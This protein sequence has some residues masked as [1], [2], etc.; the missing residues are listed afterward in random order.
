MITTKRQIRTNDDRY[1]ITD[2][3]DRMNTA[4]AAEDIRLDRSVD[5]KDGFDNRAEFADIVMPSAPVRETHEA[6]NFSSS[7]SAAERMPVIESKNA[8]EEKPL[9]TTRETINTELPP[10]PVKEQKPH[11][12]E[13]V[14][15][16][17]KTLTAADRRTDA[18]TSEKTDKA[19]AARTAVRSEPRTNLSPKMKVV[20]IVCLAVALVLA[21]AVIATGV[22]I[23][24]ASAESAVLSQAIAEKQ[25]V[26][27]EQQA[28]LAN[29]TNDSTIRDEAI[30]NGMV[31]A[32]DPE[33][34]APRA[35]KSDYPEAEPH[36]NGFD[37][38]CDWLGG[39][40]N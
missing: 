5:K 1:I 21:I 19:V 30:L 33:Y 8:V 2:D 26:I 27:A 3:N 25:A 23:S 31:S 36:T 39:I 37:K 24:H 20:L 4:F 28:T 11:D 6:Y 18:I 10:R 12:I 7:M 35:E 29:L 13:D 9:Y 15:P 32:S 16:S 38:F 14:M 34:T 22:S 17:F 40:I